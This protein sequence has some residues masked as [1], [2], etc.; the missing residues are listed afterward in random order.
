MSHTRA[1]SIEALRSRI[2]EIEG[3]SVRTTRRKTGIVEIDEILGGIPVPGIMEL[4]GQVGEGVLNI[5]LSICSTLTQAG[6]WVAWVDMDRMLYPPALQQNG[7]QLDR[8]VMLRPVGDLGRWSAEA[9]ITSGCF[10]YVVVSGTLHLGANG[11]RWA[12]AVEQGN[13]CL[14]VVREVP[15]RRLPAQVR[16]QVSQR[17]MT[18]VRNRGGRLGVRRSV[19][20]CTL[21]PWQ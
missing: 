14:C 16:I 6:E 9:L 21:E 10:S 7:I 8:L 12:R 5:A 19:P 2:R 11:T 4:V 17:L 13:C 1:V 20:S 3:A 18:V 15:E